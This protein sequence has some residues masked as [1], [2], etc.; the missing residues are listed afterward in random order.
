[1]TRGAAEL[2][3]VASGGTLAPSALEGAR[4]GV[5]RLLHAAFATL[6]PTSARLYQGHLRSFARYVGELQGREAT[7]AE[8]VLRL[9]VHG[10][11]PAHELVHGYVAHLRAPT[12]EKPTGRC[13]PSS[14]NGHLAA[15]E[16]VVTAARRLAVRDMTGE[17]VEWSLDVERLALE[18]YRD[19]RGHGRDATESMLR[20]AAA[21][22]D[23]KGTRDVA[24]LRLLWDLGLRRKEVVELDVEHLDVAER[25][26]YVLGKGRTQRSPVTLPRPTVEALQAWLQVRGTLPGPLFPAFDAVKGGTFGRMTGTGIYKAV[27]AYGKRL[28]LHVHPHG[29]RHSAITEALDA[30]ASLRD[31]AR[32]A[33]HADT[34]V[35]QRYDD[36]RQDLG[37][38]VAERLAARVVVV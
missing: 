5:A 36:N 19:T 34:R 8:A 1:M 37:G 2:V 24:L 4:E 25:R 18:S 11:G 23:A 26:L 38:A 16:R 3:V 31:A 15:L 30:G 13:G 22:G 14:V 7:V 21:R 6:A 27:A 17:A 12:A 32:F 9:L 20:L 28:G 29:F 33:R 35:T 10:R